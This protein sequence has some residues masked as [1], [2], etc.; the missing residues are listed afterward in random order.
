MCEQGGELV[1]CRDVFDPESRDI[2]CKGPFLRFLV[3]EARQRAKVAKQDRVREIGGIFH[4]IAASAAEAKEL[5]ADTAV[6]ETNIG[7]AR[8]AYEDG[9]FKKTVELLASV[10]RALDGH[11]VEMLRRRR[12]LEVVQLQKATAWVV[13]CEPI[14]TEAASY[15]FDVKDAQA[16]MV[17]AKAAIMN[18]DPVNASKFGRYIKDTIHRIEKDM[19]NK[20]LE[21]GTIKHVDGTK[22]EKCSQESLY[23]YPN[24]SRKCLTCGFMIQ[25]PNPPE[26]GS[27]QPISVTTSTAGPGQ[28]AAQ[29]AEDA[30]ATAPGAR[31]RRLIR[32]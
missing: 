2:K 9:S 28:P 7:D 5:G 22:C 6:V 30:T 15:G 3:N 12:E 21:L 24:T 16:K 1:Y 10:D 25:A 14:L 4:L 31:K 13:E 23:D 27:P 11:H 8:K 20:R 18:K 29:P 19:D 32:W 17:M 26:T